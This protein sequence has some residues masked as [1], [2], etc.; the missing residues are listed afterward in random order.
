[1]HRQSE[2]KILIEIPNTNIKVHIHV[3]AFISKRVRVTL[4]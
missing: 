2:R 4:T 1:M 3:F